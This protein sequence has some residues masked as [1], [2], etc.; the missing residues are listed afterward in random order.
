MR[1]GARVR[2]QWHQGEDLHL[3][4]DKQKCFHFVPPPVNLHSSS[5]VT[6][7]TLDLLKTIMLPS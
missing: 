4:F 3:S 7:E 1:I 2:A 5:S 6:V